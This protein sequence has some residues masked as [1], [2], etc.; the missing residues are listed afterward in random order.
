V[1]TGAEKLPLRLYEAFKDRF[2][3]EPIEGYGV[4]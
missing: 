3:I 2:G 1:L 4:T